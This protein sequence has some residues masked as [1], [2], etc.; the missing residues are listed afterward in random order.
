ML[1]TIAEQVWQK[2]YFADATN[3]A[4]GFRKDQC[5]AWIL[6]HAYGDRNS[7]YGWEID[8][9]AASSKGGS[10][11]LGNLRPLHWRNNATRQDD[12]LICAVKSN[13]VQN[14]AA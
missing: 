1:D 6:K 3:E 10:D 12:R 13:G 7:A 9:I 5:G 8:H 11:Q 2:A 14:I 4:N